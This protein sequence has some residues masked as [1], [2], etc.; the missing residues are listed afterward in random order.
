MGAVPCT[1]VLLVTDCLTLMHAAAC[2]LQYEDWEVRWDLC[3]H[4][5][6]CIYT[7]INPIIFGFTNRSF[8]QTVRRKL[9]ARS[10]RPTTQ[11]PDNGNA[12]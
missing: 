10:S 3:R 5:F 2:V 4:L 8:R 11:E 1:C 9:C 6:F 12:Q 7:A